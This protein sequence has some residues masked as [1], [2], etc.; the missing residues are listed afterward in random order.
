MQYESSPINADIERIIKNDTSDYKYSWGC[1]FRIRQPNDV[2]DG[3]IMR[4]KDDKTPKDELDN[5]YRPLRL[6]SLAFVRDY[7]QNGGDV[8]HIKVVFGAGQWYKILQYYRDFLEVVITR[9]PRKKISNDSDSSR[10]IEKQVFYAVPLHTSCKNIEADPVNLQTRWR[11]DTFGVPVD[12]EFQLVDLGYEKLR[13]VQV[14][15]IGRETT[16]LDVAKYLLTD[17]GQ[18]TTVGDNGPCIEKFSFYRAD[19]TEKR[20]H[21]VIPQGTALLDV[22]G[23]IQANCGGIYSNGINTYIQNRNC[24]VYPPYDIKRLDEVERS[25]IIFKLPDHQY[26][27]TE[28]TYIIEGNKLQIVAQ[29]DVNFNDLGKA[30]SKDEGAGYR[31]GDARQHMHVNEGEK[32]YLNADGNKLT[33]ERAKAGDE[34]INKGQGTKIQDTNNNYVPFSDNK[35]NANPFLDASKQSAKAGNYVTLTWNNSDASL[36]YPAMPVKIVYAVGPEDI[37][38]I[39]GILH[40]VTVST[41]LQG[42]NLVTDNY[43][44]RTVLVVYVVP[45]KVTNDSSSSGSSGGSGSSSSSGN[46]FSGGNNSPYKMDSPWGPTSNTFDPVLSMKW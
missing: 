27:D 37:G 1:Y 24:Y 30:K 2:G 31:A 7:V 3:P 38:E 22:P 9:K 12:V 14:G 28:N 32:S 41:G 25:L 40:G 46:L 17:Q 5:I 34:V 23:Y 44:Q 10:D 19:N 29:S 21:V 4:N 42:K 43:D 18:K 45:E 11:L 36:L 8:G 35:I 39:H 6:V 15:M 13:A 26:D 33:M 20:E 16:G